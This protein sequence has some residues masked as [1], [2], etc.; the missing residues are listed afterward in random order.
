MIKFRLFEDLRRPTKNLL[1]TGM[2]GAAL[3]V[4]IEVFE[5]WGVSNFGFE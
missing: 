2:S 3:D 1:V 5:L 4:D